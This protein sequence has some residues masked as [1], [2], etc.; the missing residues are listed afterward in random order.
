MTHLIVAHFQSS[1]GAAQ[2]SA[3]QVLHA[4]TGGLLINPGPLHMSGE[5]GSNMHLAASETALQD[6]YCTLMTSRRGGCAAT[7]ILAGIATEV[8]AG[9]ENSEAA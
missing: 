6:H 9:G 4:Q 3:A 5:Q 8:L 1:N 2:T 7:I